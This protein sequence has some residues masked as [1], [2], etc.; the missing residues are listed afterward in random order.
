[1]NTTQ[2]NRCF[3]PAFFGFFD[4]TMLI[5][6]VHTLSQ[7]KRTIWFAR[8]ITHN[9]WRKTEYQVHNLPNERMGILLISI[10]YLY[11][12]AIPGTQYI[13]NKDHAV[14][15]KDSFFNSVVVGRNALMRSSSKKIQH[16]SIM[17]SGGEYFDLFYSSSTEYFIRCKDECF[18]VFSWCRGRFILFWC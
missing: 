9:D 11:A 6:S 10:F 12:I 16:A 5:Y 1:M 14:F 8:F 13:N 2:F 7:W 18:I 15:V 17:K 4:Q 3:R